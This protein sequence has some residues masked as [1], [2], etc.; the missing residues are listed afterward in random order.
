MRFHVKC[1]PRF[2]WE[3]CGGKLADFAYWQLVGEEVVWIFFYERDQNLIE[4]IFTKLVEFIIALIQNCPICFPNL[5]HSFQPI[6]RRRVIIKLI[7]RASK[8]LFISRGIN[9]FES[10]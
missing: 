9:H 3:L 4:R 1:L 5:L 8:D 2:L 10:D 6:K 7:N